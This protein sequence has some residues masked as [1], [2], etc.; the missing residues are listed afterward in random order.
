MKIEA[1]NQV[2]VPNAVRKFISRG[3]IQR[4]II[5]QSFVDHDQLKDVDFDVLILIRKQAYK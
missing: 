1:T 5:R 3:H 4:C 2:F